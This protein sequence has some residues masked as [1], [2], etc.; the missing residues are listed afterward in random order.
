[1]I[2]VS[3]STTLLPM[4]APGCPLSSL[5]VREPRP[6]QAVLLADR[7]CLSEAFGGGAASAEDKDK[8]VK[9]KKQAIDEGYADVER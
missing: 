8:E 4:D 5:R 2:K 6:H 9:A 7:S 3:V 1:V